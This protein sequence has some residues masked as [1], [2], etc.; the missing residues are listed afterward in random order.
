MLNKKDVTIV[1]APEKGKDLNP[2]EVATR[3]MKLVQANSARFAKA[4]ATKAA[5][6]ANIEAMKSQIEAKTAELAQLEAEIEKRKAGG[7]SGV[8]GDE[9][10][11]YIVEVA[12]NLADLGW[13]LESKTDKL[14][15]FKE[16]DGSYELN[17]EYGVENGYMY[18]KEEISDSYWESET[19]AKDA[20]KAISQNALEGEY[21]DADGLVVNGIVTLGDFTVEEWH[22]EEPFLM[23]I[24][25]GKTVQFLKSTKL[26]DDAVKR[27]G[28]SIQW[29]AFEHTK[30]MKG[31]FDSVG[32]Y[33]I[34][35]QFGKGGE[36]LGRIAV[37]ASG[38]ITLYSG[39]SGEAVIGSAEYSKQAINALIDKA[40]SVETTQPVKAVASEKMTDEAFIEN[41]NKE[42][43]KKGW[44]ID[45]SLMATSPDE[46]F[47][48]DFTDRTKTGEVA[49]ATVNYFDGGAWVATGRTI[50]F[51]QFDKLKKTPEQVVEAVEATIA[52]HK[53]SND[54]QAEIAKV[55]AAY[56]FD[57]SNDFKEWVAQSVNKDDYS[58]F[59]SA[60]TIDE[61]VKAKGGTVQWG[62]FGGKVAMD[63]VTAVLN[64]MRNRW[65]FDAADDEGKEYVGKI[66]FGGNVIARVDMGDDGK[67]M[68]FKGDTGSVRA[69]YPN[70]QDGYYSED[71]DTQRDYVNSV[72]AG[73][74]SGQ[75]NQQDQQLAISEILKETVAI[76]E[77]HQ[78]AKTD[79]QKQELQRRYNS[80]I[81]RY[82][83]LVAND[84][85]IGRKWQSDGN[86]GSIDE[87]EIEKRVISSGKE[88]YLIAKNGDS[89]YGRLIPIGSIDSEIAQD[90]NLLAS[91]LEFR[92]AQDEIKAKENELKA[93]ESEKDAE[94]HKNLNEYLQGFS[95]LQK[96]KVSTALR[97]YERVDGVPMTRAI[98]V[99][100]ALKEGRVPETREV[101][102]VQEMSRTAFN[103][104][105]Q[106]EQ[107]FHANKIKEAGTKTDYR[108]ADNEQS[109]YYS[110]TK[111]EYDYAVWLIANG[112]VASK[113]IQPTPV[114]AGTDEGNQKPADT[115]EQQQEDTGMTEAK[116]FLQSVI[117]GKV[118]FMD[119]DLIQKMTEIGEKYQDD[120]EVYDL[121]DKATR[122]YGDW[123]MSQAKSM[124]A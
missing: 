73:V 5:R 36:I 52:D 98:K 100:K 91:N 79:E 28:G 68:L 83:E 58:P 51:G 111:T 13:N 49:F 120:K 57:A 39:S 19:S 77:D 114:D 32:D 15:V 106:A 38:N 24:H 41:V 94:L 37:D 42:L 12:K 3:I 53:A 63:S 87:N 123:M 22:D 116:D 102:K 82:N 29:G 59:L 46:S 35:A 88:Y 90:E 74:G 103:R 66:M 72:F 86:A 93:K 27:N 112:K 6:M 96:S 54:S 110:V 124:M 64:K 23:D 40:F 109:S 21:Y 50:E 89:R 117:D 95:S 101:N 118:D 113:A 8:E 65:V 20:A 119:T 80:L 48:V 9:K 99:E 55:D 25:V 108:L 69:T 47:M 7:G 2:R 92:K 81:S 104:A 10:A 70:G 115:P 43:E 18:V 76:R 14:Y 31:L 26:I 62:F 45:G 56:K 107:D 34:V 71:L 85:N 75:G 11:S 122:V 33:G 30:A 67:V 61:A 17:I 16:S 84:A 105:T 4:N 97:A 121:L 78:K 1:V 44:N 60:K